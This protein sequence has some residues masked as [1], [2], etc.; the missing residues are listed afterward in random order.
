[1]LLQ[2]PA[3]VQWPFIHDNTVPEENVHP[4]TATVQRLYFLH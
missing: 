4:L 3:P 2:E 1:M